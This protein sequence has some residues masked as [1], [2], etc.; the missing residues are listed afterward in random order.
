[1]LD[2]VK[3]TDAELYALD[4]HRPAFTER[5]MEVFTKHERVAADAATR[6]AVSWAIDVLFGD[7][8]DFIF[9]VSRL[10]TAVEEAGIKPWEPQE[11]HAEV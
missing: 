4:P 1:M 11:D 9:A 3:L 7:T 6:K 2:E 10:E 8:G 5:D